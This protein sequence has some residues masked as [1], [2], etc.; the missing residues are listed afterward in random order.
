M[1]DNY[2]EFN[3]FYLSNIVYKKDYSFMIIDKSV[4]LCQKFIYYDGSID[5]ANYITIKTDKKN[6]NIDNDIIINKCK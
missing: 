3:T 1:K 5:T 4:K 6:T 2:N